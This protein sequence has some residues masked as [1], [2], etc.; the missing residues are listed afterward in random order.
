MTV[1]RS[2]WRRP[3][4]AVIKMRAQ[5]KARGLVISGLH[6]KL[7][8]LTSHER[9]KTMTPFTSAAPVHLVLAELGMPLPLRP[10]TNWSFTHLDDG[11]AATPDCRLT[12]GADG[13]LLVEMAE[14]PQ[15]VARYV[16]DLDGHLV[17]IS[18]SRHADGSLLDG[19]RAAVL[20][21][22]RCRCLLG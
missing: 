3:G 16:F 14:A 20:N 10:E 15:T 4:P 17:G 19:L 11:S 22:I 9:N 5:V 2:R 1:Q 13:D 6:G 7:G 21:T 8:S 12:L 18:Q